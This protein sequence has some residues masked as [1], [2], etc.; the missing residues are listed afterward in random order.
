MY[1]NSNAS[2]Q[3]FMRFVHERHN[4]LVKSLEVLVEAL[5]TPNSE[6]DKK[7][8]IS[9]N[10]SKDLE[11]ATSEKDR[12]DWISEVTLSLQRFLNGVWNSRQ[13]I[14]YL[15]DNMAIVKNHKWEFGDPKEDAFDFDAIFEH[16]R[17]ES[18]LPELFEEIVKILEKIKDSEDLDS[19]LMVKA[20]GRVIATLNKGKA[21]SYFSINGAWEFL[22]TFLQNYMWI[23]LSKIPALGSIMQALEKTIKETNEEMLKVNS[24]IQSEMKSI[25]EADIRGLKNKA[26]FN[27]MTYN[28]S[29]LKLTDNSKRF[30][31]NES[32]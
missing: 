11:S 8:E 24:N 13:L 10:K 22:I 5:V 16:Y 9:F 25:V 28:K 23:E 4:E 1:L 18:R 12:P 3:V 7:A 31:L 32:V 30:G 14:K 17:S 6:Q 19:R 2:Y 26:S 29:G 21:G 15:V 20:L 27:F